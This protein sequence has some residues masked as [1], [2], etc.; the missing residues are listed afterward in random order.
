M[1]NR[2]RQARDRVPILK[3]RQPPANW[4]AT[5]IQMPLFSSDG[6]T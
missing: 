6:R 5:G 4:N 2:F 1:Y 3:S